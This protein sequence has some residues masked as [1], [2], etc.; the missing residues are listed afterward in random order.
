MLQYGRL[1]SSGVGQKKRLLLF[2]KCEEHF[3]N[4]ETWS[5]VKWLRKNLGRIAL[6]HQGFMQS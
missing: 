2:A 5:G 3:L 6:M 1:I 4:R